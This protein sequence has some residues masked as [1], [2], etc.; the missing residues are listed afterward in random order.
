MN[1]PAYS[2]ERTGISL[3]YLDFFETTKVVDLAI[4]L[5]SRTSGDTLDKTESVLVG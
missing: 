4:Q 2:R 3:L 1:L 5:S